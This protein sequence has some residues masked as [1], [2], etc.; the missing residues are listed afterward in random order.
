[1]RIRLA[2]KS[3]MDGNPT[4]MMT[5]LGV[6]AYTADGAES[7]QNGELSTKEIL[8]TVRNLHGGKGPSYTSG[9]HSYNEHGIGS[10]NHINILNRSAIIVAK[11]P[12]NVEHAADVINDVRDANGNSIYFYEVNS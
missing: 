3:I 10:S 1:V 7:F 6:D 8:T 5:V 9:R 4:T 2:Q 12:W 11:D